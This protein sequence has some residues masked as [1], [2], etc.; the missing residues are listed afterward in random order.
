MG[1]GKLKGMNP[2]EV[3]TVAVVSDMYDEIK[4]YTPYNVSLART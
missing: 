2:C 4:V 1:P 3:C